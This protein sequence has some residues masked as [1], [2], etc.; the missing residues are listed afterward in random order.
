MVV[1]APGEAPR[2]TPSSAS[3]A[4]LPERPWGI[5]P[6]VYVRASAQARTPRAPPTASP[7]NT[8]RRPSHRDGA[9]GL[10]GGAAGAGAGLAVGTGAV[11][12]FE[13]GNFDGGCSACS[14]CTTASVLG[15]RSCGFLDIS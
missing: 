2:G 14:A 1:L 11:P 7:T 12:L 13:P 8:S 15:K 5:V 6:A 4:G 3:P 10:G 9:A